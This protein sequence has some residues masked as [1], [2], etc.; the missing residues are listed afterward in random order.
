MGKLQPNGVANCM[1]QQLWNL[2]SGKQAFIW[3]LQF[4]VR[5]DN[6]FALTSLKNLVIGRTRKLVGEKKTSRKITSD[7]RQNTE[8]GLIDD[9]LQLKYQIALHHWTSQILSKSHHRF[10]LHHKFPYHQHHHQFLWIPQS[11]HRCQHHHWYHRATYLQGYKI[12][13]I[14][15]D[16]L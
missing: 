12:S 13:Q 9:L 14:V 16:L 10:Q 5:D 1:K 7:T 4:Y 3:V 11:H 8:K 15:N 6:K 2:I